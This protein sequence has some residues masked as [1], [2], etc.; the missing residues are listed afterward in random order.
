MD[1]HKNKHKLY[2]VYDSN[3]SG[4]E[5]SP[6]YSDVSYPPHEPE[7]VSFRP[8]YLLRK[9][10]SWSEEISVEFDPSKLNKV[11]L[12]TVRYTTGSSFGVSY[13]HWEV[14]SAYKSYN[15]AEKVRDSIR[16]DTYKGHKPWVGYFE[17]LE[18]VEIRP[19]DIMSEDEYEYDD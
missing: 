1:K 3:I 16:D 4:G 13:G 12:V 10:P 14:I 9:R 6:G 7:Y 19:I 2:L 8:L 15:K 17:S 18:D 11:Y 5:V